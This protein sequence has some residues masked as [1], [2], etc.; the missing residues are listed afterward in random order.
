MS[1]DNQE[2]IRQEGQGIHQG[3]TTKVHD[4]LKRTKERTTQMSTMS[5]SNIIINLQC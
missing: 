4:E 3:D 5:V 1:K 2:H